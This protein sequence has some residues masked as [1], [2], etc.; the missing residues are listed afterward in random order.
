MNKAVSQ[1]S[2]LGNTY[3]IKMFSQPTEDPT[4]TPVPGFVDCFGLGSL[5]RQLPWLFNMQPQSS[6][7]INTHFFFMSR[8]QPMRVQV[9]TCASIL[10]IVIILDRIP[11]M[12]VVFLILF[13]SHSQNTE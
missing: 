4:T 3:I 11:Q 1:K 5:T 13:Q 12:S 6:E 8:K 9:G 7:N 10:V 2:R